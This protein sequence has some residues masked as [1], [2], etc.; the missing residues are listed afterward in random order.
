V[1]NQPHKP[2]GQ[3]FNHK[4]NY[5]LD[6]NDQPQSQL[7]LKHAIEHGGVTNAEA[8]V[9]PM[10]AGTENK[11]TGLWAEIRN[12]HPHNT[13]QNGIHSTATLKQV[14]QSHYRTGQAQRVPG[15]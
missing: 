1:I 15:S 8:F 9:T 4:T 10:H 3:S 14:K 2:N 7:N 6:R 13:K 12:R 11:I 5:Q